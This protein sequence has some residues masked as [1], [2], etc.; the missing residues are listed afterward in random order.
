MTYYAFY[1]S[2]I[3][4]LLLTEENHYLTGLYIRNYVVSEN[5]EEDPQR[6]S[7]VFS[8]L[9]TY[10]RGDGMPACFPMKAKGT[11]F[12]ELVWRLLLEIPFGTT[13]TYGDIAMEV[14][15]MLGKEKMSCQAVGQ[16]VGRNPISI[17]IPCHRVVGADG[18][19][20]GYAGGLDNK[21]WLL[22][23]E[24]WEA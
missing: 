8:W 16:A 19:L 20:T 21:L 24:G 18:R 4:R 13:R 3:G 1:H 7:T 14:A 23:H 9:D 15:K 6:F 17:I 5:W 2:P 22:R 12:Q 10:F 11:D